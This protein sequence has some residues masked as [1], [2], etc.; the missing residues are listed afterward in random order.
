[1]KLGDSRQIRE[2]SEDD[3]LASNEDHPWG[4]RR[5]REE[6]GPR[7]EGG[8]GR[9]KREGRRARAQPP[10]DEKGEICDERVLVVVRIRRW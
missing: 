2:I 10:V 1:M 8:A 6:E 7:K 3:L 4:K 9:T 5:W